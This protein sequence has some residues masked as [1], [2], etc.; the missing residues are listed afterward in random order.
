MEIITTEVIRLNG[1]EHKIL[2]EARSILSAIHR[3]C[4]EDGEIES[5][6]LNAI[7]SLDSLY[8]FVLGVG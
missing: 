5:L 7:E 8:D 1:E 2:K 3:K 4:A 6:M